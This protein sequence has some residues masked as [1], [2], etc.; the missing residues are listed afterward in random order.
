MKGAPLPNREQASK[1]LCD[2]AHRANDAALLTG[3]EGNLSARLD[4]GTLLCTPTS[5]S[6]RHVTPEDLCVISSDGAQIAGRR[7]PSSEIALHLALYAEDPEIG[8]VVHAH[9]PFATT[10]AM[11]NEP[12]PAGYHPEAEVLLGPVPLVPYATP[13]RLELAHAVAPYAREHTAVLL[14]NHGA[15]TWAEDPET[16]LMLM[17]T[18][19]SVARVLYQA[20]AIGTPKRLPSDKVEELLRMRAARRVSL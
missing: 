5:L 1:Q 17:E 3:T 16:A 10:F 7:S 20:R 8:A 13:G 12:L 18:V 19:E 14:A 15:V 2:A 6:K 4:N 9:P 11:L